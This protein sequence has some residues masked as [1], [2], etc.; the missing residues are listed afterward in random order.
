MKKGIKKIYNSLSVIV[1]LLLCCS[2]ST[3][4]TLNSNE[5]IRTNYVGR[6]VRDSVFLRDSIFV[7]ET[8]DTVFMVRNRVVYRDRIIRDTLWRCD[9]LY[10][11][12]E[13]VVQGKSKS[14]GFL[15]FLLPSL[16]VFFL[17]KSGFLS[18]I[19]N[20]ILKNFQ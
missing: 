11:V 13:I 20:Y 15:K 9:T 5:N 3:K 6:V 4:H 2:C 1:L 12:K 17:W 14:C 8:S 7:R 19:K 10:S 16:L 18:V